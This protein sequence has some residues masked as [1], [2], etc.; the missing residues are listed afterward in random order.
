MDEWPID[1]SAWKKNSAKFV[2]GI[3]QPRPVGRVEITLAPPEAA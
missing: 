3:R 2:T 1:R